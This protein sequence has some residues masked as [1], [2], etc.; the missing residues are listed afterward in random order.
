MTCSTRNVGLLLTNPGTAMVRTLGGSDTACPTVWYPHP[1]PTIVR[2][3][4]RA[5]FSVAAELLIESVL[6][7]ATRSS[8][9][10]IQPQSKKRLE[11]CRTPPTARCRFRDW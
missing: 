10:R 3:N 7:D 8:P 9:P 6:A 5:K 2:A 11:D 1:E 4:I